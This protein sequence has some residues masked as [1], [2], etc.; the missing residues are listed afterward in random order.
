MMILIDHHLHVIFAHSGLQIQLK[1]KATELQKVAFK[2]GHL[3]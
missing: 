1:Q 2:L 3:R